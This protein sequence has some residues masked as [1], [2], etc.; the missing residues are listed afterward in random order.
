M[1][2]VVAAI[3]VVFLDRKGAGFPLGQGNLLDI[4]GHI[5]QQG[6]RPGKGFA[7]EVHPFAPAQ[8]IGYIG[9]K[10]IFPVLLRAPALGVYAA[11]NP[12]H[13]GVG[14]V[15]RPGRCA[16]NQFLH[17][18]WGRYAPVQVIPHGPAL[19]DGALSTA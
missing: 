6:Q 10:E 4:P 16:G 11:G 1:L 2:A 18:G 17:S 8:A 19:H 7:G 3:E 13:A 15:V 12:G 14:G 5:P 9:V